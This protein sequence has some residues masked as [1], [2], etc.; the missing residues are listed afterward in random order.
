MMCRLFDAIHAGKVKRSAKFPSSVRR[1]TIII[2]YHSDL[3]KNEELIAIQYLA[4]PL[5]MYC[6][7]LRK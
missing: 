1:S 3:S 6:R 4:Q 7:V 2:G 5:L